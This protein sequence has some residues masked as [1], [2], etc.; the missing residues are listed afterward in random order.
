MH[1]AAAHS[2]WVPPAGAKID[3]IVEVLRETEEIELVLCRNEQSAAFMAAGAHRCPHTCWAF[4]ALAHDL[5][6]PALQV[7]DGE[8]VALGSCWSRLAL[9][10]PI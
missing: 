7:T 2:A 6:N 3:R 4:S 5:P 10:S 9:V 8:L 1:V